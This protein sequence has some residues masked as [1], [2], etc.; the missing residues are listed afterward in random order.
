MPPVPVRGQIGRNVS[1]LFLALGALWGCQ[2]GGITRGSAPNR[3]L[4]GVSRAFCARFE[5]EAVAADHP[6]A[7]AA[8][9]EALRAGGNAVD[10][11]VAASFAL[12]V[13]RPESCG[14][15]GGG[16]MVIHLAPG[17]G[18]GERPGDATADA[19]PV[20]TA[21]N[22][23][24]VAPAAVGPDF[25]EKLDDPQASVRGGR[26][27]GVPGTVAGLLY[28]LDRYGR[29]DRATVLA[30]AVRLAEEGFAADEYYVSSGTS[31]IRRFEEH[32]EWKERFA[33]VWQRYLGQGHVAAGDRIQ[34]PEQARVLRL[35]ADRGRAGFYGGEVAAAIA[36]AAGRDRGVLTELDLAGYR[37]SETA[38]LSFSFGGRGFITMPPPSSGGV[39]MAQ[40]LGILER[41]LPEPPR[42]L[43]IGTNVAQLQELLDATTARSL[44]AYRAGPIYLHVLAESMKHAFADRSRWLGDPAFAEVPVARLLSKEYL[45]NRA[46]TV[47]LG[48]TLPHE[49]YGS[50]EPAAPTPD[51]HGTSHISVVD[52]WGGAVAC[53]E[54]VNL[55]FGSCIAVP[56]YGI[57]LNNQMDD[58][59]TR[60]GKANAF[61][62]HQSDRNLPAPGKRPLS[63]M[64]PTIVIDQRGRVEL[65]AGASGG[66]RIITATMQAVLNALMFRDTAGQAVSRPRIHHQWSPDILDVE[67]GLWDGEWS[68][69]GPWAPG[70]P[71]ELSEV[72]R[73]SGQKV[74]RA[75]DSADVQLI[76]RDIEGGWEAA[77]DP[78]KGGRPAGH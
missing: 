58:F 1:A 57:L 41:A 37:V 12:S 52:R 44:R 4:V 30:P 7:S 59:T 48:R 27:I 54:T 42:T 49:Q 47:A 68:A 35:I 66:P 19:R 20:R 39:A 40:A 10:A 8:G 62:L 53:T 9:E 43:K 75:K 74:E 34:V 17:T 5:Q 72:L 6:A 63:S 29:L 25:Y 77:C 65:V 36:A 61:G 73:Q 32:P 78:R 33:F 45:D 46:A 31:L 24:E 13:V 22:Y 15:G 51:D 2:T 76:H 11:A 69:L 50:A 26:A 60:R 67:A 71:P 70:G 18:R 21:L 55:A 28:A 3:D 56:E 16:F 64:T 14:I 23:R 38:P